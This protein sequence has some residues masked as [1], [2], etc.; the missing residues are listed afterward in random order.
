M[1]EQEMIRVN[2]KSV[3]HLIPKAN[4]KVFREAMAGRPEEKTIIY[5][6]PKLDAQRQRNIED[7]IKRTEK[8]RL[9]SGNEVIEKLQ[10]EMADLKK[11]NEIALKQNAEL[12]ALLK[13][14][15]EEKQMI[16]AKLP[17]QPKKAGRPKQVNS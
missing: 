1:P 14:K 15:P 11:Q 16:V 9:N 4:E 7:A 12:I 6:D 17:T 13:N 3:D 2:Y 8:F 5:S 10:S